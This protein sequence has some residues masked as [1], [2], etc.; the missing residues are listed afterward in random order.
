M[1]ANA[2]VQVDAFKGSSDVPNYP[3]RTAE[4]ID[5]STADYFTAKVTKAL[6]VGSAGGNV[7]VL[8]ADGT[9]AVFKLVPAGAILPI[10]VSAVVKLTTTATDIVAIY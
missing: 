8:M 7:S 3:A 6:Y 4:T 10:Q 2:N 1:A 5:L 9:K